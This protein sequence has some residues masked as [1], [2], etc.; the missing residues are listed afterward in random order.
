MLRFNSTLAASVATV[1]FFLSSLSVV[2]AA[3]G[4]EVTPAQI[5]A[6]H[7]PA[8]H[9]AI[10]KQY[11]AEAVAAEAQAKEH[12]AMV[13]SYRVAAKGT[14]GEMAKSMVAHCE[15]L[16]REYQD[17]ATSYKALAADHRKMAT[18]AGK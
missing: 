5:I 10:A 11:E 8:E 2:V 1:G 14:K 6:A 16:V 13:Q 12:E 4:A 9:E 18:E 15:A 17:A 7:S 3:P